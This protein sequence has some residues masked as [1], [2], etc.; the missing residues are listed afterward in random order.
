L[1]RWSQF[2]PSPLVTDLL[3][4]LGAVVA[5]EDHFFL[6]T[7]AGCA[8]LAAAASGLGYGP[9]EHLRTSEYVVGTAVTAA[10]ARVVLRAGD[11]RVS[12][13]HAEELLMAQAWAA[14]GAPVV[15]PL[16]PELVDAGAATVSVWP[17]LTHTP[18]DSADPREAGAAL[19]ELHEAGRTLGSDQAAVFRARGWR[20]PGK[21]ARRLLMLDQAQ[22]HLHD[23]LVATAGAVAQAAAA[24]PDGQRTTVHGDFQPG[25]W[26][27]RPDGVRVIDLATS[28]W[29]P[30]RWDLTLLAGRCGPGRTYPRSFWTAFCAGYGVAPDVLEGSAEQRLRALSTAVNHV[31]YPFGAPAAARE[32]L[33]SLL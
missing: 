18:A 25:N 27:P 15:A 7:G 28:G 20:A 3:A 31:V 26:L 11:R 22:P 17:F 23:L 1:H 24:V 16:L 32:E 14:A 9:V 5:Q 12:S 29:G 21:V 6:S 30:P 8:A 10:G 19:A 13:W 33:E 4:A 2:A